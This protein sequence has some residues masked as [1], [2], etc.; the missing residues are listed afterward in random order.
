MSDPLE[1]LASSAALWNR[2]RLD[3]ESDE[4]LAQLLDRGSEEDW[5]ALYELM[6]RPGDVARRLRSRALGL[7]YEVPT[8]RP[9]FWLAALA[10]LGE[11]IDWS[12]SP[13]SDPGWADI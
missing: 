12:R 2:A 13:A 6:G 1:T 10:S 9:W 7:L 5:R 11:P 8:G 3:L 4:I